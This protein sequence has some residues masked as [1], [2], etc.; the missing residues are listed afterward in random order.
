[1]PPQR[2][3]QRPPRR[4]PRAVTITDVARAA[5]VAPSTVSRAVTRPER[6]NAVTR[7]HVIEVANRLGYR[8]S[9]VARALGSG[10]NWILALVL[11]DITNPYFPGVIRGAERPAA[12]AAHTRAVGSSEASGRRE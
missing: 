12:A 1:M 4:R 3:P 8:P 7:E 6:V 11:P 9:P 2:P 5:G 10:R